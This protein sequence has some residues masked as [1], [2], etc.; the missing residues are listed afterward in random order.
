MG[1]PVTDNIYKIPYPTASPYVL[2]HPHYSCTLVDGKVSTNSD[3]VT[4]AKTC[5]DLVRAT[6]PS[7]QHFSF[8]RTPEDDGKVWCRSC[9]AAFDGK[10]GSSEISTDEKSD[11][12]KVL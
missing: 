10:Y 2:V 6:D 5:Y 4:S 12:Y 8:N 11:V 3:A 9:Q 1:A 7:T